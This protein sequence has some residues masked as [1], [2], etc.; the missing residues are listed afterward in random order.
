MS[1][2]WASN[3]SVDGEGRTVWSCHDRLGRNRVLTKLPEATVRVCDTCHETWV[4]PE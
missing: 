1:E 3:A 4:Q 2:H